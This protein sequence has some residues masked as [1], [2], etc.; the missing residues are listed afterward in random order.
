MQPAAQNCVQL[1]CPNGCLNLGG[2]FI[3]VSGGAGLLNFEQ[4]VIKKLLR[5]AKS[6]KSYDG[7][8]NQKE[9]DLFYSDTLIIGHHFATHPSSHMCGIKLIVSK[10][11][12]AG[13]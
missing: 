3:C 9:A 13:I 7:L 10:K 6:K 8:L 5:F 2:F 12:K 11:Q 4:T 1:I